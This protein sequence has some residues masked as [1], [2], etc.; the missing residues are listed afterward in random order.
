MPIPETLQRKI[1]LFQRQGPDFPRSVRTVREGSWFQVMYGQGL[2]PRGYNAI[3]DVIA[4]DDVAAF[5]EGMR[6]RS[7]SARLHADAR[8]VHRQELQG[9]GPPL[10]EAGGLILA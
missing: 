4:P 1:E 5:I 8:G 9:N 6:A 7:G 3:V 2:R 10:L